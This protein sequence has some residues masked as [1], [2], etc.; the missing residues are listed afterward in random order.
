MTEIPYI[1]FWET[2][3]LP[4]SVLDF[5]LFLDLCSIINEEIEPERL[6]Q[7]AMIFLK[8]LEQKWNSE[9]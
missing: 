2:N 6:L 9:I 5:S 3:Y 1:L 4:Y 8:G 7:V